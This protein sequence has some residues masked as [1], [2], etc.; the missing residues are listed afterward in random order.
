MAADLRGTTMNAA[1]KPIDAILFDLGETLIHWGSIDRQRVFLRAA[2]RTYDLWAQRQQRM[3]D[4]HRYYM[5]QWFA[6]HWGHLKQVV[7][8][9]EMNAM[10]YLERACRK[11]WLMAP[12]PFFRELAWQWYQPLAEIATIEPGTHDLLESLS[13]RGYRLAIVSNT[14]VPGAVLDRHLASL[15]LLPFF[16]QRIYSCDIGYRKP[17]RRI[18][19]HALQRVGVSADRAV[20][21]GD[22]YPTDVRGAQRAGLHAVW[23]RPAHDQPTRRRPASTPAITQLQELPTAIDRL[24]TGSAA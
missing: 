19:S 20:F 23:K 9:R 11:L 1:I 7:L 12:D 15:D 17:D 18:F 22:L 8:R 21:V 10:R 24:I 5:H 6:L 3:P 4:F 16:P 13:R 2:H 14:F